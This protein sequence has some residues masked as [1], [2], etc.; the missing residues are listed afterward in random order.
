MKT[1]VDHY[2][3]HVFGWHVTVKEEAPRL[4]LRHRVVG[5]TILGGELN[6]LHGRIRIF[7]GQR[8]ITEKVMRLNGDAAYEIK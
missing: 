2:E 3:V 4:L 6:E 5:P 8:D 1:K 7:S